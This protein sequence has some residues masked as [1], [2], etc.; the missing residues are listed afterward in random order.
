SEYKKKTNTLKKYN[1]KYFED[2]NPIVSDEKYD[3]LKK[4]IL[5]LEEKYK[6]LKSI[7]SPTNSVGYKPSKHFKKS[8]HKIPML[9]LANAFSEDDLINF[10]KKIKN[11]LAVKNN[12]EIF[13]SA[14]PKIDGISASLTY[15]DGQIFKGLS[16]GDGKEGEDITEN[17]KTINDIPK[18]ISK[19]D[20]PQEID[21]RGEVFIQNSDFEKL[22][23]KFANPRNAASG[24]LRQKNPEETKKIPLKFIAYTFGYENGLLVNNQS[25]YLK[26]LTEWGFKTNPLNILTSGIK[27]LIK[28]YQEIEKKRADID[29][30]I[31]GIVYKVN[32]FAMQKR[33]GS[34][35]NAPRW[36]IAHKFS[37]NK[38][39]SEILDIEIQ[40]GRTGAL[41]PVAKIKPINI[42]GVIVSNATLHNEDEINRKD[43][44]VGDTAVIERAG[45]VIPHILSVDVKKRLKNSKK[46]IFPV[47]C[48]SCGSKTIKE[49][50]KITKKF[51]AVRR[52]SSEGY[53]CDKISIEKLKHFV[54]KEAFNVDGFG[55]KIVESFWKLKLIKF[56]QDI[57]K[58]DYS[59]IEKLDGWGKLSVQNLKYSIDQK[60]NISLEKLIYSLGIRY[61]GLENAKLLSKHFVSFSKFKNL[62]K[63]NDYEDL[64]NI[65]GIGETQVNSIKSF[66]LN[67]TNLKVLNELEKVLMIK[68]VIQNS[69][70]GLL[71]NKTFLVTGKL[72]GISRAEVKSLIEENS[73]KTVSSVS[74]KLNYLIIGDKPTK[75]K[76][77][78]AKQLNINIIDQAEFLKMLNK[79]S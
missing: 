79:T 17:L 26:K 64:L 65:D 39:V 34:V 50:N 23:E 13:Y 44:R 48:P 21:I 16:R 37:S 77:D 14:E 30:D 2:S 7:H 22:K 8:K 53:Y 68:N 63:Q 52:C 18:K 66:F 71:K 27:N 61:I 6:Y 70:D 10:E 73:G 54:S 67:E 40:V 59:K 3:K 38:A 46:F 36:A 55:K 62:S 72:N 9:S 24:S 29:F 60:K 33:L 58:L 42:G 20:F 43:I 1:K 49:F 35:A 78:S 19:K 45:D 31:D 74:K 69:E 57:F 56:P 76:I 75:K 15:K 4:Q 11:F 41:T 32:D 51:D 47:N 28:N 5:N 25:D 12:S